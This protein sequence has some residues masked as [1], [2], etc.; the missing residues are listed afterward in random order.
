[1]VVLLIVIAPTGI[2]AQVRC[3]QA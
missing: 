3:A 2:P 1:M